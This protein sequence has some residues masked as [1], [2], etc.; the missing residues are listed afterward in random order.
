MKIFPDLTVFP[1]WV[2]FMLSL[3]VL[4]H[5]VF[6]PTL[7]ILAERRKRTTGL[8]K[9]V[10]YFREQ[11]ELKSKKYESL[12]AEAGRMARA[13]RE[14]ILKA[15][16]LEQKQLI[17]EARQKVES[18]LVQIKDQIREQTHVVRQNLRLSAE[19]LSEQIVK[20]LISEQAT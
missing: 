13:D 5:F 7:A 6:K 18:D 1:L 9:E 20:K 10:A 12:M 8:E 15:A 19:S 11:A 17:T 3:L 2:I 16:G 14:Q 4:N